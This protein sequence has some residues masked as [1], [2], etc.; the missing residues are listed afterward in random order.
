M[1]SFIVKAPIDIHRS[2]WMF[3]PSKT[4]LH[5]GSSLYDVQ[6]I[7]NITDN[8]NN[9]LSNICTMKSYNTVTQEFDTVSITKKTSELVFVY[10]H[11]LSAKDCFEKL[12]K[13]TKKSILI[14]K[15]ALLKSNASVPENNLWMPNFKDEFSGIPGDDVL[16]DFD[17]SDDESH[18]SITTV[19]KKRRSHESAPPHPNL[20]RKSN[21]Q[22]V[23]AP[24]PINDLEWEDV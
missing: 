6:T 3:S 21:R 20:P 1:S 18:P 9:Y 2:K 24:P 8:N 13:Q 7:D 12:Y 22:T 4:H 14:V 5:V 11:T 16:K 15:K 10:D 19:S 17:F 23:S